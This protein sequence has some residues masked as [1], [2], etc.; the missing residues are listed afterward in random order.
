[1][2]Y[3]EAISFNS[4][5]SFIPYFATDCH[6]LLGLN[7][8]LSAISYR[9]LLFIPHP[10]QIVFSSFIPHPSSFVSCFHPSSFSEG[11]NLDAMIRFYR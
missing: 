2:N 9:F 10:F 7:Y 1:M 6:Q 5:S 11:W 3:E 4:Y 8:W